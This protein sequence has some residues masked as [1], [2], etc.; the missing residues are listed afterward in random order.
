MKEVR[1]KVIKMNPILEDKKRESWERFERELKEI[2]YDAKHLARQNKIAATKK[3][4]KKFRGENDS[5]EID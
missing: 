5:A 3:V 1:E 2:K 4:I